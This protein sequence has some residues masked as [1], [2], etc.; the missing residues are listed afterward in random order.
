MRQFIDAPARV[1]VLPEF[2]SFTTADAIRGAIDRFFAHPHDHGAEHEVWNWWHVPGLYTYLRTHAAK[3]IP[4]GCLEDFE[5][6][7][8]RRIEP[9]FPGYR[10]EV[11]RPWLSIYVDGCE[12]GVHND[13]GNGTYGYVYSLTHWESRHFVG[14][15][16]L[17]A[18]ADETWTNPFGTSPAAGSSFFEEVPAHFN[19]L[20]LFDDRLPHAVRRVSGTSNP[21]EARTVLHGHVLV[22]AV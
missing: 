5:A 4:A 2:L 15:E 17:I 18:T 7:I 3:V 21:L 14:G 9:Q 16:T 22:R 1:L 13:A 19:Q 10:V 6:R 12:Q 11:S 8:L 20:L